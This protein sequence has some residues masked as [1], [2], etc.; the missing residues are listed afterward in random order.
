MQQVEEVFQLPVY[1]SSGG[2]LHHNY[3]RP[4]LHYKIGQSPHFLSQTTTSS[5]LCLVRGGF[6]ILYGACG[7]SDFH[8]AS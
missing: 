8:F 1:S 4:A 2:S 6:S 5:H 3:P 7:F